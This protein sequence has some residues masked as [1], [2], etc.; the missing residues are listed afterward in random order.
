ML[1]ITYL[2]HLFFNW[3]LYLLIP[4]TYFAQTIL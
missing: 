4:F 1:Y 2:W 3:K